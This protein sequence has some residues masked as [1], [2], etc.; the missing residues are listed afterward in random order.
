MYLHAI[1]P[2]L[3]MIIKS[4]PMDSWQTARLRY[5]D[6][7]YVCGV[8]PSADFNHSSQKC[9]YSQIN[10]VCRT[11]CHAFLRACHYRNKQCLMHTVGRKFIEDL[12]RR[13]AAITNE[14][15]ETTYI[16]QRMSVTLQRGNA[17]AFH[18]TFP[19]P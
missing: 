14:P 3:I 2:I 10:E 7:R 5:D 19:G 1:C 8:T 18:N 12:G 4:G 15:L 11:R 6:Y 17:V 9:S 16:Y 13:I